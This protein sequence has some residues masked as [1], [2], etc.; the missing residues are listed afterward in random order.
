[1][2]YIDE[3]AY[4]KIMEC[5]NC[6]DRRGYHISKGTTTTDFSDITPCPECG[7]KGELKDVST[8]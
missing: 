8:W 5:R 4:Y 2:E 1:M 3:N 7:C 6:A